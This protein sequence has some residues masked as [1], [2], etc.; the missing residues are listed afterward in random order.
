MKEGMNTAVFISGIQD[1]L[2]LPDNHDDFA[3]MVENTINSVN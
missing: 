2:I 1:P 3:T